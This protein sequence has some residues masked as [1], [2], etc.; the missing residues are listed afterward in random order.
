VEKRQRADGQVGGGWGDDVE[1]LR[2]WGPQA[3]GLGSEIAAVGLKRMAAGV[4]SSGLLEKG[5]S[6]EVE[7]SEHGAE[8]AADTQPL[9]AALDPD[10]PE[11]RSRLAESA[12][13]L[14]NWIA[15]QPDGHWRF[16]SYFF[17]CSRVDPNAGRAFDIHYNVRAAGLALWQ[18]YLTRDPWLVDLLTKWADSWVRAMR[19]TEHGKPPGLFPPMI[20]S[21]D[22]SYRVSAC[23]WNKPENELALDNHWSGYSQEALASLVLAAYDLSG[24]RRWLDAAAESFQVLGRCEE[25]PSFCRELLNHPEALYEWRRQSGDTRFDPLLRTLPG[26]DDSATLRLLEHEA[27]KMEDA[28]R[29]NLDMFTTEALFTDRVNPLWSAEYKLHL[30][31]GDAP[32][33]ERYPA[34]S[35]TW[36]P[37][38]AQFARAVLES[39]P[40]TLRLR[41]YNFEDREITAPVLLWRLEPGEYERR[42][43][44][45]E[46][47]APERV[48]VSIRRRPQRVEIP[49]PARAEASISF[50][51]V[52]AGE[53]G[54]PQGAAV[55]Q[56]A[57]Q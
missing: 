9:L 16:R 54:H 7:D 44:L 25:F 41:I 6:R 13:C 15:R 37:V 30:F 38:S 19:S 24:Q 26:R 42:V 40:R 51:P 1:M 12:S 10:D 27:R 48:R 34:F 14:R 8:L 56:V 3:L 33:G 18:A 45:V 52:S 23:P 53:A 5:Y 28:I 49:V 11:I 35:V 36:P 29:F 2:S 50:S 20:R 22:G 32:R 17:N 43:V 46:G 47:K 57:T 21:S 4:W 31:G 55:A 39:S